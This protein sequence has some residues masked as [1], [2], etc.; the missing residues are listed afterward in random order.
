V[1]ALGSPGRIARITVF[2]DF[3]CPACASKHL[4]YDSVLD[5]LAE[6]SGGKIV[7]ERLD[8]PLDSECNAEIEVLVHPAACEAAV[9]NRIAREKGLGKQVATYLYEHHGELTAD[10]VLSYATRLGLRAEYESRY[11]NIIDLIRRDI[12]IA[13]RVGIE[14]TPTY[15]INGIRIDGSMSPTMLV[16]VVRAASSS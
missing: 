2:S 9:L 6:S 13:A 4:S 12:E 16:A 8:F 5:E 11:S 10:S 3:Q 7:V 15:F 1:A 14:G